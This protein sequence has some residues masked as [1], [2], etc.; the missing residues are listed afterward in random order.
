MCPLLYRGRQV[1][2]LLSA[3]RLVMRPPGLNKNTVLGL[4]LLSPSLNKNT[5]LGLKLAP[6]LTMAL[7]AKPLSRGLNKNT[8]LGL[9]PKNLQVRQEEHIAGKQ[10]S[11]WQKVPYTLIGRQLEG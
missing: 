5:V 11:G 1:M 2:R 3:D 4:N 10:H 8:V 7:L 9:K 6:P